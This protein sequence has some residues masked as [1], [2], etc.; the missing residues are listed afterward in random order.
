MA[1]RRKFYKFVIVVNF[2]IFVIKKTTCHAFKLKINL[3]FNRSS[4]RKP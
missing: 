1:T 2:H 3:Y 4:N